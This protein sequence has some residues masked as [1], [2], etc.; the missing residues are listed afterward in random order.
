MDDLDR[1]DPNKSS[2]RDMLLAK[3]GSGEERI[4]HQ[5]D[6]DLEIAEN[7]FSDEAVG[8]LL[9]EWLI[10]AVVDCLIRDLMNSAMASER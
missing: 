9:D 8:A 2:R 6:A 7:V 10:P 4:R 5:T 1:M 3:T